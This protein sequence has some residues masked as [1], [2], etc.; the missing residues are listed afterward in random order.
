MAGSI[1]PAGLHDTLAS[2]LEYPR[3]GYAT[4]VAGFARHLAEEKP[5]AAAA[6]EPFVRFAA[7]LADDEAEEEFIRTFDTNSECAL[8]V[9]WQVYGETYQR[10]VFLTQMRRLLFETGIEE[11][12]ELPDHLT[13]VLRALGRAEKERAAR[14]LRLTV[15]P[16]L[17]KLEKALAEKKSPFEPVVASIALALSPDRARPAEEASSHE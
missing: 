8:E 6:L 12:S 16:A 15:I 11:T 13:L 14:L 9:G 4:R 1:A 5:S 10:G 2:L 3:A 17:R 7:T